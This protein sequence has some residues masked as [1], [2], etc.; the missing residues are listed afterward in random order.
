MG[1][2]LPE[3]SIIKETGEGTGILFFFLKF[4]SKL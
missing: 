2:L 4:Y 3:A 1:K